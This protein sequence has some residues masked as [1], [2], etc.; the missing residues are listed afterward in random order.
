VEYRGQQR[1]CSQGDIAASVIY[2][3]K[4]GVK[5]SVVNELGK[6]AVVALLGPGD[7]FGEGCLAGVPFRMGIATAIVPTSVL[8]I[9]KKEMTRALHEEHEL[10]DRFIAYLL[11]S[12]GGRDARVRNTRP[13]G[14]VL[15]FPFTAGC[16]SGQ[17]CN[18]LPS[19]QIKGTGQATRSITMSEAL[20]TYLQDHLA[21]SVHAV[22]LLEF[23]RDEHPREPLGQFA[24][25]LL[26]EIES[27]RDVLRR[28]AERVGSGSSGSKEMGAWFGERLSRVKL[29]HHTDDGLGTFEALEFLELGIG[30]KLALWRAL[31][32]AVPTDNRLQGIDFEHLAARAKLQQ[33]Q[34]EERR[35]EAAQAALSPSKARKPLLS[36]WQSTSTLV[37]MV[38]AT[39]V[40]LT[41]P[42]PKRRR[43]K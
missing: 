28:L 3:Q 19:Q 20:A 31:G 40:F 41:G 34:V 35:L 38:L 7:F 17:R 12:R 2:I 36:R 18:Y 30:G 10:S 9:E 29:H 39:A 32:A 27:D 5:L 14:F 15:G 11:G 1:I 8:V 24:S 23:M 25:D 13:C 16:V 21:G 22:G 43:R 4:G 6:E 42:S 37:L 33:S 26:I